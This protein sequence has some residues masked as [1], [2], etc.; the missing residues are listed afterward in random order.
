MKAGPALKAIF[1]GSKDGCLVA[2]NAGGG[3]ISAQKDANP[4]L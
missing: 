1:K 3:G 2:C 4:D